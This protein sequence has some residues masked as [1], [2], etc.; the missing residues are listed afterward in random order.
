MDAVSRGKAE[1]KSFANAVFAAFP[2]FTIQLT[3]GFTAGKWAA[4]EW[5][6]SGTH[7]GAL[8]GLPAT[9]KGFAIR[10]STICEL[11]AG[12]LKRNSDY[13]DLATFLKQ[14]GLMPGSLEGTG[15]FK[16]A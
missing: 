15:R 5:T 7:Q 12:K 3:S 11:K 13:W 6:M 2:D 14:I 10:G 16:V 1:V 4:A 8:P 9:G